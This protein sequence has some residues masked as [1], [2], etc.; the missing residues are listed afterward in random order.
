MSE[1]GIK[2]AIVKKGE[3]FDDVVKMLLD[4]YEDLRRQDWTNTQSEENQYDEQLTDEY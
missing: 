3:T 2:K 1:S 4:Y